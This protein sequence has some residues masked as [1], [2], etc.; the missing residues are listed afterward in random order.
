M[1]KEREYEDRHFDDLANLLSQ[2]KLPYMDTNEAEEFIDYLLGKERNNEALMAS[3]YAV[4][5]HPND[6]GLLIQRAIILVDF[7]RLEEARNILQ[8]V[9]PFEQHNP[10]FHIA[11]GDLH[12]QDGDTLRGI[13]CYDKAVACEEEGAESYYETLLMIASRLNR[14][15]QWG[16]VFKYTDIFLSKKPHDP[17]ILFERAYA[18]EKCGEDS[19]SMETYL[20]M[21]QFNPFSDMAWYNYA[22]VCTRNGLYENANQAF[23]RAIALAPDFAEAYCNYGNMFSSMDKYDKAIEQYATYVSMAKGTDT[24]DVSVYELMGDC[25]FNWA[26]S[27]REILEKDPKNTIP[28]FYYVSL[29]SNVKQLFSNAIEYYKLC[30]DNNYG[31]SR[32]WMQIADITSLMG[33][34]KKGIQIIDKAISIEPTTPSLYYMKSAM[35]EREGSKELTLQTLLEGISYDN[36]APRPWLECAKLVYRMTSSPGFLPAEVAFDTFMKRFPYG[37]GIKLA[38]AFLDYLIEIDDMDTFLLIKEVKDSYPEVFFEALEDIDFNNMMN[39][40]PYKKIIEE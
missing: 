6:S 38:K 20:E 24:F 13:E 8:S 26:I 10:D 21:L 3:D 23:A 33:D 39:E 19:K 40:N 34:N 11:W 4:A 37:P 7:R 36:E 2:G 32:A 22:L 1:P 28:G 17:D 12:V 25:L 29:S 30:I 27:E 14:D 31:V 35:Y 5:L 16:Y 15:E 18:E 9:S